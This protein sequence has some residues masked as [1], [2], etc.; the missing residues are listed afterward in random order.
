[1][2]DVYLLDYK[3]VPKNK[4]ISIKEFKDYKFNL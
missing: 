1:M 2:S 4:T 3:T